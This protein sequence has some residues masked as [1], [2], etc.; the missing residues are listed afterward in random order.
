MVKPTMRHESEFFQVFAIGYVQRRQGRTVLEISEP[1]VPALKELERFSHVQVIW[2]L[3]E[4]EDELYREVVQSEH[5]P[6]EAPVLGVFAC[7]SPVRPNPIGLTT[8]EIRGVDHAAGEVEIVNIDAFAGTP[9]LDLKA[10]FPSCDRVRDVRVP[11][12]AADW[13]EWLPEDGL[14]L[15]EGEAD[16]Q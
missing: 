10:Y 9:I 8:V 12:W 3:S 15:E 13:P 4:F 7:R 16:A 11:Q 2:W 6:Y 5:A 14:G 1:F